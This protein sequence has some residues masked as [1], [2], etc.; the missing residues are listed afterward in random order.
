M[1]K[2]ALRLGSMVG[3]AS[4]LTAL[5]ACTRL[6]SPGTIERGQYLVENIAQCGD[7]HSIRKPNGEFDRTRWLQGAPLPF[8]PLVEMPWAEYAPGLAGLPTRTELEVFQLLTSGKL[9]NGQPLR[10]PMPL[11]QLSEPDARAVIAY[12]QSLAGGIQ[13]PPQN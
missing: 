8:G 13:P 5:S 1:S 9:P 6:E 12:L 11:Y 10:P 4:G 7:C 2:S 3:L